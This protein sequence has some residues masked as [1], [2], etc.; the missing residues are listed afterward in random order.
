MKS[1]VLKDPA[2]DHLHDVELGAN[3]IVV[4]AKSPHPGN[5]DSL[6]S[7]VVALELIIV[8]LERLKDMKLAFD[9]VGGGREQWTGWLPAENES[10][11]KGVVDEISRVGLTRS[12]LSNLADGCGEDVGGNRRREVSRQGVERDGGSNGSR[13]LTWHVMR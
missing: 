9:G 1:D 7:S 12:E 2:L 3:D 4:L 6:D 5:R 11:V 13:G 8:L 10:T